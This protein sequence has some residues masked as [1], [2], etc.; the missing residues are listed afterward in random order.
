MFP[1]KS[2][3]LLVFFTLYSLLV[4]LASAACLYSLFFVLPKTNEFYTGPATILLSL[5]CLT[6]LISFY[7]CLSH[8]KLLKHIEKND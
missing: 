5:I 4:S 7:V 3:A 8:K 6:P 2:N 1:I